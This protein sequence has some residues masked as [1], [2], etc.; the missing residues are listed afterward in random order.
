MLKVSEEWLRRAETDRPG[1]RD[2][3]EFYEAQ[4]LPA[5]PHCASTHSAR[6]SSGIVGRSMTVAA[7]TTKIHLRP[8]GRP[9]AYYCNDC[10]TYFDVA[11]VVAPKET[12]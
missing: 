9:G 7:A 8:N 12:P 2:T 5:C 11:D 10:R 3:I 1:I 6:V 4:L